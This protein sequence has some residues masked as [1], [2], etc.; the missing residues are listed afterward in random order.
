M[1]KKI[2]TIG[3]TLLMCPVAVA[4][5]VSASANASTEARVETQE[6]TGGEAALEATAA[7]Q[8][9]EAPVRRV[10][11]EGEARGASATEI[12]H[13]AMTVHSR[14]RASFDALTSA[15]GE[16][17]A[18]QA[19]IEAGAEAIASG[20]RPENVKKLREAAPADR[21]L[22]AS[23]TAL[24]SLTAAG[25]NPTRAT[26]ELAS[27]LQAG[28][29]DGAIANLAASAVSEGRLQGGPGSILGSA[30]GALNLGG[31]G[32]GITAGVIGAANLGVLR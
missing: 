30:N 7:S 3:A 29:S 22:T 4:A 21:S 6:R 10:I 17:A 28:A 15:K 31:I 12:D 8:L 27:Q 18:S 19:E 24:A 25:A 26:A 13:A 16:S 23:L 5:Q 32:G 2:L 11:A 14:L 9:P 20:A 1:N